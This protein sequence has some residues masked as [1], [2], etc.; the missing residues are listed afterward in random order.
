MSELADDIRA[1]RRS[2]DQLWSRGDL[3][4]W[5]MAWCA[6]ISWRLAYKAGVR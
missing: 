1:A 2:A 6:W 3:I 5:W 4:G